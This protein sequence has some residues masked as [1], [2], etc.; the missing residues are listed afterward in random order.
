MPNLKAYRGTQKEIAKVTE[1]GNSTSLN[2]AREEAPTMWTD[3]SVLEETEGHLTQAVFDTRKD[4]QAQKKKG[5]DTIPKDNPNQD[6]GAD[7]QDARGPGASPKGAQ[8]TAQGMEEVHKPDN[9]NSEDGR[10]HRAGKYNKHKNKTIH[11][12]TK[13]NG[14]KTATPKNN[15]RAKT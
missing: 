1:N 3:Q 15:L 6:P 4:T 8:I 11:L 12:T 10:E 9:H 14:A 2:T 7:I 13:N 5:P